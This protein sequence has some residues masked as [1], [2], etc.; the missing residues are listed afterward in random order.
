MGNPA[1]EKGSHEKATE[2]ETDSAP[3]ASKP[4]KAKLHNFKILLRT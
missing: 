3:F 1:G 4:K 2:S